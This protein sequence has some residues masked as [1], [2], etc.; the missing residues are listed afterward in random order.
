M[1]WAGVFRCSSL[2][3]KLASYAPRNTVT[4]GATLSNTLPTDSLS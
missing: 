3:W 2:Q 1:N 4:S